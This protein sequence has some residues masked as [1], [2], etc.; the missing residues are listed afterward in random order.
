LVTGGS[1]GIGLEFVRQLLVQGWRVVAASRTAE[2]CDVLQALGGEHG[3][4]LLV[5]SVDVGS[6]VS[7]QALLGTVRP[8]TDRLDLLVNAAG[9]ISGDEENTLAFGALDQEELARTFLINS[10]A[11]LMMVEAFSPLLERGTNS[12]VVNISSLN[13]SIARWDRAGKYSYAASKAAL[14]MITKGLSFELKEAG[15]CVVAF[16]P[17]WVKT[18][19]T[20]NEPAPM[21]P[22]ESVGGML[23]V[24][25]SLTLED[26]G[27]FLDWEGNEVPW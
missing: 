23:R 21:D 16:H 24:A 5:R 19:M 7:R 15:V 11:P 18:W 20:R 26:S 8:W 10:I 27:R 4:R 12:M 25:D 3:V 2:R 17:G 1:S 6:E 13:G 22:E 14:N 9:I